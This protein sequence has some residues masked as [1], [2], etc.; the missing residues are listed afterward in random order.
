MMPNG[1]A[2]RLPRGEVRR[3]VGFALAGGAA[4]I[5]NYTV[6]ISLLLADVHYLAASGIGYV[7]GIIVSFGINRRLIFKARG[8]AA[9][10]LVLYTLAYGL[11]LVAQLALLEVLVR[12]GLMPMIANGVALLV[13]VV[14]NYFV[15]KKFVFA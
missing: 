10:Q 7:S 5:L 12:L 14:A 1:L 2:N 13:V 4:T 8:A 6:F 3:F 9:P 11:A 15:I